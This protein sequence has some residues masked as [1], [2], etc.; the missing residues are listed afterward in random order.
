MLMNYYRQIDRTKL[1]FDFLVHR[2]FEADY[3][4]EIMELG[5]RIYRF[6]RLIPWSRTYRKQLKEFFRQHPEYRIV[7]VHQDCLSAVALQCAMEA[8]VPVR[9][10]HS[11]NANQSLDLKYL[12]KLYYMKKIPH[13]ATKL[14]AC[15]EKAGEWMFSGANFQVLNNAISVSSYVFSPEQRQLVRESLNLEKSHILVGHVGQFRPQKNHSFLVETFFY[16]QKKNPEARLLL[17]GGGGEEPMIR[18]QVEQLGIE[19]KVIFAGVRTDVPQLLQA[20]DVFVFPSLFEGL[21]I[22]AI[23]AQAS[24][25][26]CLISDAVPDEC[27]MTDGLVEK[28]PLSESAEKWAE[29]IELLRHIPRKDRGSEIRNAGYDITTEAKKLEQLYFDL[30]RENG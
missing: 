21:G 15:S 18:K 22:S 25:L 13:Y 23:E 4:R 6:P 27:I 1:Q 17:V 2:P 16:F 5:G 14:F 9:I 7:H 20:M 8:G 12:V 28:L 11:H 29:K 30:D 3:D 26:P 10:G 24:G 19:E